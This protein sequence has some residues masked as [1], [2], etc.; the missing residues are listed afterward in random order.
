MKLTLCFPRSRELYHSLSP[1]LLHPDL[2]PTVQAGVP[3][4]PPHTGMPL[5]LTLLPQAGEPSWAEPQLV[6]RWPLAVASPSPP[7]VG[8]CRRKECGRCHNLQWLKIGKLS[9]LCWKNPPPATFRGS[10][11]YLHPWGPHDLTWHKSP[12]KSMR[13]KLQT[14]LDML[15]CGIYL[16]PTF[17]CRLPDPGGNSVS[18]MQLQLDFQMHQSKQNFSLSE[19]F[20]G[21]LNF[22]VRPKNLPF[23]TT[24]VLKLTTE[25]QG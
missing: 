16:R 9:N 3:P 7:V 1:S 2:G 17:N 11:S 4:L 21:F 19:S 23:A 18:G 6:P 10:T 8:P 20:W 24:V 22:Q 15:R 13:L 25:L 12:I 14:H 5:P